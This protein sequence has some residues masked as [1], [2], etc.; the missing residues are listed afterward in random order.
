MA[1]RL[2]LIRR[3]SNGNTGT[4]NLINSLQGTPQSLHH[5][6][7]NCTAGLIVEGA[8]EKVEKKMTELPPL[9]KNGKF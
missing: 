2:S 3:N 6:T 8:A 9:V 4:K 5:S 1:S 7:S